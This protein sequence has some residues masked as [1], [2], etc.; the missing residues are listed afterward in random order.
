MFDNFTAA[1]FTFIP[2]LLVPW[3]LQ[4]FHTD[5]LGLQIFLGNW[6]TDHWEDFLLNEGP[7]FSSNY[8]PHKITFFFFFF[9]NVKTICVK[10]MVK[11][12]GN[13]SSPAG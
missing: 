8:S 2:H 10:V 12:N 7:Q 6:E 4:F 1:S 13:N 11:Y 3:L 5:Y 9:I